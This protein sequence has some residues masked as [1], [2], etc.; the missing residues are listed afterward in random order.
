MNGEK[1]RKQAI[2]WK[3]FGRKRILQ[4]TKGVKVN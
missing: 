3:M 1:I 2:M 4:E